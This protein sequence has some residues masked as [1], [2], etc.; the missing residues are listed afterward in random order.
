ML[1]RDSPQ[2]FRCMRCLTRSIWKQGGYGE[3]AQWV[4]RCR[5]TIEDMGR[6]RFGKYQDDERNQLEDDV[7]ALE[8]W[9]GEHDG[10]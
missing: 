5:R 7:H 3:A 1:G 10:E 6:G 8:K 4:G 9:R 2:A